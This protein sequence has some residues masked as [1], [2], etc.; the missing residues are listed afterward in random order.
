M[1][2]TSSGH[3]RSVP[4]M[5]RRGWLSASILGGI[6]L[7]AVA[8]EPEKGVD[9]TAEELAPILAHARKVKLRGFRSSRT[10]HYLGVGNAPELFR[11]QAL[12]VCEALAVEFQRFYGDPKFAVRLPKQ[13]LT[14][15][16]LK[17]RQS[18]EAFVGESAGADLGGHYDLETNQ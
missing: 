5:S 13:R 18:Y 3:D 17:D 4:R 16:A 12:R 10:P 7:G 6:G 9:T 8:D 1:L 14:V 11:N 15:I 2:D